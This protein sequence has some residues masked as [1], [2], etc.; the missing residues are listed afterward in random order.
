[1][2]PP[3]THTFCLPIPGAPWC[4][5]LTDRPCHSDFITSGAILT[6]FSDLVISNLG[7]SWFSLLILYILLKFIFIWTNCCLYWLSSHPVC[8]PICAC[9]CVC[10]P[11]AIRL[12]EQFVRVSFVYLSAYYMKSVCSLWLFTAFTHQQYISRVNLRLALYSL[13]LLLVNSAEPRG[14][15]RVCDWHVVYEPVSVIRLLNID[16]DISVMM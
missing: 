14:S 6:A 10:V 7:M 13:P 2:P 11:P 15:D 9:V 1:M 8:M 5:L 12:W 3:H 4:L 16:M